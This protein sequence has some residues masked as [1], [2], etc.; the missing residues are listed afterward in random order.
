M[1]VT[2][3]KSLGCSIPCLLS[4]PS[5]TKTACDLLAAEQATEYQ[6]SN[7]VRNTWAE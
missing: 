5:R 6:N 3:W 1:S 7:F 4:E 2:T